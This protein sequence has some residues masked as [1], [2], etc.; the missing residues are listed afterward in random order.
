MSPAGF[1]S[2]GRV[3]PY[4]HYLG[5]FFVEALP[6]FTDHF[7]V[8]DWAIGLAIK[9]Q[10]DL[11]VLPASRDF[12]AYLSSLLMGG[13]SSGNS[14]IESAQVVRSL[15]QFGFSMGIPKHIFQLYQS[16]KF[17]AFDHGKEVNLKMYG[18][19]KPPSYADDYN[20]IQIPIT[21]FV[22]M[23]DKL[24]RADDVLRHFDTLRSVS[25]HLAKMKV[26]SGIGHCDFNYLQHEM[27]RSELARILRVQQQAV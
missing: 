17:Q 23:D 8:P 4:L 12:L 19:I 14:F 9:L 7:S 21:F 10:Q 2:H 20:L 27:I 22:S 1:H 24:I 13:P 25:P 6:L 5:R 16:Q 18:T 26:F 3:T 11:T 15:L